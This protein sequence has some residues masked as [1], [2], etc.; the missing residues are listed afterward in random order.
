MKMQLRGLLSQGLCAA[1]ALLAMVGSS[2]AQS[3]RVLYTWGGSGDV[4]GWGPG[5]GDQNEVTYDNN[6]AGVLRISEGAG[7]GGTSY[8]F[9]DD[10][11]RLDDTPGTFGGLDLYGLDAIEFDL[12]MNNSDSSGVNVSFF[13]Q[14]SANFDFLNIPDILIPDTNNALNTYSF[15]LTALTDA[16]KAHIR[17]IGIEVRAH[18]GSASFRLGEVRSVGTPDLTRVIASHNGG[19]FENGFNGGRINFD[20]AAVLGNDGNP[21]QSGLSVVNGAMTW[22]DLGGGPGAAISYQN[23]QW[24]WAGNDFES[25]PHD[26]SNYNYAVFTVR[27]TDLAGNVGTTIDLQAFIQT[28]L[29]YNYQTLG[30]D[31]TLA[32]DGEWYRLAFPLAGK[33]DRNYTNNIS[34]NLQGHANDIKFEIGSMVYTT[35]VPVPE[36]SSLGLCGL[37]LIGLIGRRQR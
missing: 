34:L 2:Q 31:Q 11:N 23:G 9:V 3:P 13:V 24:P 6:I 28:N 35:T 18:T 30:P 17:T 25:R 7:H 22:T 36:P 32:I 37:M 10:A 14:A 27:A 12:G 33:A 8:A 26:N 15:P 19:S 4:R 16:Q 29:G 21:N 20:Q 5:F 1:A